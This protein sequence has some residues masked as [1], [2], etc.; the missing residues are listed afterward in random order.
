MKRSIREYYISPAQDFQLVQDAT[1]LRTACESRMPT[2]IQHEQLLDICMT[3][4]VHRAPPPPPLD[5]IKYLYELYDSKYGTDE[6]K[7]MC[8]CSVF[9]CRE[10]EYLKWFHSVGFDVVRNKYGNKFLMHCRGNNMRFVQWYCTLNLPRSELQKGLEESR[11]SDVGLF[12]S[13]YL[14]E[15]PL[16]LWKNL[17][18]LKTVIFNGAVN[19]VKQIPFMNW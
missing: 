12:L 19:L 17:V 14:G 13:N 16:D 4:L 18:K 15:K 7:D 8:E 1:K 9:Y 3:S 5:S 11:R 2:K 10:L 6:I